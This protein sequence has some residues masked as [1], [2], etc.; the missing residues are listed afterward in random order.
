[1]VRRIERFRPE[2]QLNALRKRERAVDTQ[3]RFE[4]TG[5]TQAV[6]ADRS[7]A[8]ARLRRPRTI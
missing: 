4:E 2:L 6:P 1:M 5:A 8:R 3:V 7:K